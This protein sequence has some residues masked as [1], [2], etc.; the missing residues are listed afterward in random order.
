MAP[1]FS[2]STPVDDLYKHGFGRLGP[3]LSHKLALALG[4]HFNKKPSTTVTIE[5]L[6]AYLPMRYEDRSHPARI[7]DLAEGMEASV[8]LQVKVAGGYQVRNKRSFGRSRLFIFEVSATDPDRT[9]RPVVVWWFVSGSHAYE[10]VN[11]YKK[12]FPQGARFI[13][14][15]RWEWDKRRATF[16]LRLGKPA[17]ELE[18]LPSKQAKEDANLIPDSESNEE[19]A[20]ESAEAAIRS[21]KKFTPAGE[22][23]SIANSAYLAR[24]EFERSST[25][26][27]LCCPIPR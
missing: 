26:R 6:L 14:F 22:C 9:G 20:I 12:R 25:P 3:T 10:I 27:S 23:P 1:P 4:G 24:S 11:Y 16:S 19:E 5:D 15:G 7:S 8:E 2:L 18:M 13:T 17:D 21:F